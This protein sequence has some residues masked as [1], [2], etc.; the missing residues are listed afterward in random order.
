MQKKV[1]KKCLDSEIVTYEMPAVNCV[2]YE[3]NTCHGQSIP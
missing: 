3:V 1:E 2:Y